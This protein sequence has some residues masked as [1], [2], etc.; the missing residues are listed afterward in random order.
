MAPSRAVPMSALRCLNKDAMRPLRSRLICRP[1]T[2][3]VHAA[4]SPYAYNFPRTIRRYAST[5]QEVATNSRSLVTR[6]KN[7]FLGTAIGASLILGY[8]YVTDTRAGVHQ[9]VVVPSIRWFYD[10]AE[11]AHEAGT[12]A[13]KALYEFGLYPRERGS[14][15]RNDDLTV[16]VFGHTLR[17]PVG[18]SAGIDKHAEIPTALLALG[19]SVV[20][21]GGATPY[22]QDGNPKP[23][24]FRLPSQRALINRYGLNSEGAD[25]MAMR[26]RQRVREYAYAMGFG[27]DEAAEQRILDGEA[28]VPPGSLV[29]GKLMAVQVAK[30]KFTP[31]DDIEAIKNDYVYCV[32]ALARY[33]DI[34]VVNVSSPNTPGLRDLQR[35]E[36]LRNILTAVV[37]A[38]KRINRKTS[39]A[40]MV[41]VS[42]DEDSEEQV[43]GIV[44]AVWASGV[45]GVI[46]G[47]TTKRRH[48][49]IPE[50]YT[51]PNKEAAALLEQG[52]YSGPQLFERTVSL[53]K[54]YRRLLDDGLDAKSAKPSEVPNSA[55]STEPKQ[56]KAPSGQTSTA[57][58]SGASTAD[59]I[60]ATVQR[61]RANLKPA[62]S[63]A[64]VESKSQPLLRLP[65]RNSPSSPATHSA[66]DSPALSSSSHLDQLSSSDRDTPSSATPSSSFQ[67]SP[68]PSPSPSSSLSTNP[69]QSAP[70]SPS[71]VKPKVIFCTGG[72]TNGKQLLEVQQAGAQLGM[73]YTHLVYGGVGVISRMKAEMRE[74]I[75]RQ[76]KT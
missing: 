48:D 21:V 12:K 30:N 11:D 66:S 50:G 73:I 65:A 31:D 24:V 26:L 38:T 61:D 52:G 74:E 5:A 3:K 53:V 18:I 51:L 23:R 15:D 36:P 67:S 55:T 34:I 32:D 35:T 72:I 56:N 71:T 46:V 22:P 69:P 19:P 6:L 4:A 7:L 39:P 57:P 70:S 20:E 28:G 58:T 25:S 13:L 44:D 2:S 41:K 33:A 54:R 37:E 14:E 43:A 62:T 60:E 9:W 64:E 27:M 75:S 10:D 29:D 8:F 49:L 16:E 76:K 17:N 40:V 68:T 47:N 59:K 63:E 42:P 45:D 1:T